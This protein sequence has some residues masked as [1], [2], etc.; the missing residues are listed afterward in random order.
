M[1]VTDVQD[2]LLQIQSFAKKVSEIEARLARAIEIEQKV[3]QA[4]DGYQSDVRI[5]KISAKHTTGSS[6]ERKALGKKVSDP[7]R[8]YTLE[9]CV[10]LKSASSN[11][12]QLLHRLDAIDDLRK[13]EVKIFLCESCGHLTGSKVDHRGTVGDRLERARELCRNCYNFVVQTANPNTRKG[14]LPTEKQIND[15]ER[16]GR[17]KIHQ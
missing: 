7:H 10:F 14:K 9:A 17:W 1:K 2:H 15:F 3:G 11:L 5:D 13:T 12:N 4:N 8:N 16:K 6:V